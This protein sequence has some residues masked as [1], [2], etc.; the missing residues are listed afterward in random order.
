VQQAQVVDTGRY[1]ADSA[2]RT[3]ANS[4]RNAVLSCGNIP[5]S[6]QRYETFKEI[7]F[8]FSPQGRIN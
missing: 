7:V 3:F 5:I 4:A 2:F 1:F 8:N 6:A